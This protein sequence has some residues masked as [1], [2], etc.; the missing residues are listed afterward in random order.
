MNLYVKIINKVIDYIEDHIKE[1]LTLSIVSANFGISDYHFNRMFKTVT[2]ITLKQYILKRKLS[3]ALELLKE[4]NRTILDTALELGFEYPEVFSRAFKR[5][6]GISPNHY[7]EGSYLLSVTPKASI[8]ERN[9]INYKGVLSLQGECLFI[10][11]F[12]IVGISVET[13][14]NQDD[15]QEMLK[16]QTENFIL[17]SISNN[18]LVQDNFYTVVNCHH[19][20]NGEYTVFCGRRPVSKETIFEYKTRT[21]PAGWYVEFQ[22]KGDMFEIREAFIDDLYR[23][24]IIKEA[25]L[26]ANGIGMLN[27]YN[28]NYP[29]NDEVRILVPIKNPV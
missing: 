4:T 7:R 2:G 8:I 21:I 27:I 6:F 26:N 23:W 17:Q 25:E 24:I 18:G 3:K 29:N 9:I 28:M 12:E 20:D 11:E 16:S 19:Q 13:D 1:E 22:Y 14:S 5:Q 10:D 15:F